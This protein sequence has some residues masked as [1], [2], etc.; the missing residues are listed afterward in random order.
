MV[1]KTGAQRPKDYSDNNGQ[2]VKLTKLRYSVKTCRKRES[3]PTFDEDYKKKEAEQ[4]R[5]YRARKTAEKI[6]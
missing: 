6:S 2:A 4:K 1:S 3:D 5:K